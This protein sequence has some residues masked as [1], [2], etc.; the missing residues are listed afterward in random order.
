M[1]DGW[2][3]K[4]NSDDSSLGDWVVNEEKINGGLHKLA[5][6]VKK[7]GMKFG[8]WVEPEMISP[9]SDLY[10]EHPDWVIYGSETGSVVQSRGIYHFPYQQSVL[11]DEDEQCSSLGNSTTSWGA[12]SAETCIRAEI[13]HPY[14]CGQFV[15]SGFDF[16]GEPTPY[17]TR[18]SYFGQIDTAGF[19]KGFLLYLQVRMDRLQKRSHG[20]YFSLLGFQ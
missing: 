10:K 7:T 2:F 19:S 5:E 20:S 8:I 18:S 12:A 17:H 16:I 9:D 11:T 15:W 4:R 13:E 6:D 3:G 14:S 1:D